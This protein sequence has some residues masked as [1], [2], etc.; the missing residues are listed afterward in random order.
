MRSRDERFKDQSRHKAQPDPLYDKA[1][2]K[3][4]AKHYRPKDFAL[5]PGGR[6]L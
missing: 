5:R 2:P 1:H 3:K 6:H 4:G